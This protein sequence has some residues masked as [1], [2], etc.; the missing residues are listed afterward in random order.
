MSGDCW[1]SLILNSDVSLIVLPKALITPVVNV[2]DK[3]YGEPTA[4]T[5]Y[6]LANYQSLISVKD[7]KPLGIGV[8]DR[9]ARSACGSEPKTL[10]G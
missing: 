2:P 3:P 6:Q 1:A 10:A 5:G 4:T 8:I 9:T 7:V